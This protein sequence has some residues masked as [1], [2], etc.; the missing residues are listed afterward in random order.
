MSDQAPESPDRGQA[1]EQIRAGVAEHAEQVR[2][3]TPRP[4]AGQNE[5]LGA[6]IAAG[7]SGATDVDVPSLLS[8]I[9]QMSDRVAAL[10]Q[11][12]RQQAGN[13]LV[14]TAES[15]RDVL[16]AHAARTS[17]GVDH[18]PALSLADDLVDAAGNAAESGRLEHVASIGAKLETW[19][20]RHHPGPGDFH[21]FR[22]ALDFAGVHL[23]D[24]LE[25]YQADAP[26]SAAPAVTSS[27]P[28]A[29]VIAGNVTG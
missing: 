6:Q 8:A 25:N 27:R 29:R 21:D 1:D 3:S 16:A 11:E 9:K 18:A 19:L 20:K 12:K 23:A 10:E 28:P 4:E 17:T 7:G 24:A 2:A 15:L 22:Q 5:Q 14:G 13:P 26:S